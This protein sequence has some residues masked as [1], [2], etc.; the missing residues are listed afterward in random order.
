MKGLDDWL[1]RE[2]SVAQ[3]PPE[4]PSRWAGVLPLAG[5]GRSSASEAGLLASYKM[6]H[7]GGSRLREADSRENDEYWRRLEGI[8]EGE[9]GPM[10]DLGCSVGRMA[11]AMAERAGAAVGLDIR[12]APLRLAAARQRKGLASRNALLMAG[13]ALDPP[14]LA[15]SFGLVAGINILDNVPFPLTLLGQMDALLRPGGVLLLAT[16]YAWREDVTSRGEWL[17]SLGMDP[18]DALRGLLTGKVMPEAGLRYALEEDI[19]AMPWTM[20]HGDRQQSRFI[21]HM[22][23]ARK[24]A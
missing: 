6:F 2:L 15:G 21:S 9:S 22:V 24:L 23:K 11:F 3:A 20:T 7:F 13:N 10:L 5:N 19:G 14:F 16:P 12:L 18:A 8:A 4:L 1:A 17:D